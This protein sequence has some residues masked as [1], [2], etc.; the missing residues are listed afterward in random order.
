MNDV[1]FFMLRKSL[2]RV[3]PPQIVEIKARAFQVSCFFVS[4]QADFVIWRAVAP[5]SLSE[6]APPNFV[7]FSFY[8]RSNVFFSDRPQLSWSFR[9]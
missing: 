6:G 4:E 2:S 5:E 3:L 7:S 8:T 1:V 9:A